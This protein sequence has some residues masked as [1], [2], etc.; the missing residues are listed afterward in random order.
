MILIFVLGIIL[1]LSFYATDLMQTARGLYETYNKVYLKEKH[2]LILDTLSKRVIS[3]LKRED[4]TYDSLLDLWAKPYLFETEIGNVEITIIDEDRYL[5]PNFIGRIRGLD[6]VFERLF[7]I[8]YIDPELLYRLLVWT[9]KEVGDFE[10]EYPIK[11]K[12]LSSKWEI[13]LFWE[14]KGDLYGKKVG[15]EELPGLFDLI[16][17][18][19]DGKVNINTAPYYVI[20]S[21]DERID[22][23]LAKE[24]I[25]RREEEPFRDV[26]DLMNVEGMTLDIF[27]SIE[28]LIKVK[29]RYFRIEMSI[30]TENVKTTLTIV[31]DR[32]E[33]KI[34]YR[35][36]L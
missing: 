22:E 27:Y 11:R 7:S 29:S 10:S 3:L 34:V 2:F 8:L 30:E 19:S 28:P 21:L 6:R 13:E 20:L 33:N 23:T 1:S 14:N 35:E 16:T 17:V 15:F 5:N 24:I 12:V 36:L 31:Y 4:N 25:K 9:G 32:E 18:Y 26:R